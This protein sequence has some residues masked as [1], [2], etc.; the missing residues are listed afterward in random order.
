MK[1]NYSFAAAV[2][3]AAAL[4]QVDFAVIVG[5]DVEK[6]DFGKG[7]GFEECYAG[8]ENMLVRVL[9]TPN[10]LYHRE[11]SAIGEAI[12]EMIESA[13]TNVEHWGWDVGRWG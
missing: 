13:T 5:T 6:K 9:A 4:V 11:R 8:W 7:N 3:F 1:K 2:V 12:E 10:D